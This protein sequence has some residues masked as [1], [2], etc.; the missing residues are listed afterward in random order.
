MRKIRNFNEFELNESWKWAI[1]LL[2]S[3]GYMSNS[4]AQT[5]NLDT[6]KTIITENPEVNNFLDIEGETCILD[7]DGVN[8][9]NKDVIKDSLQDI[10][11][12]KEQ[13]ETGEK[14]LKF[15]EGI[16]SGD[17]NFYEKWKDFASKNKINPSMLQNFTDKLSN[18]SFLV[19]QLGRVYK[20][21]YKANDRLSLEF[22]RQGFIFG[23]DSQHIGARFK[24]FK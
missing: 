19:R 5:A 13:L 6:V 8:E 23:L 1:P 3:M 20:F 22:T 12:I 11:E 16:E 7:D 2:V 17:N 15:L 4:D 24:P 21:E 9:I 18:Q 14:V 10:K